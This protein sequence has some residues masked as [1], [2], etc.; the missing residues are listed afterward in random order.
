MF[1]NKHIHILSKNI[2]IYSQKE[3]QYAPSGYYQSGTGTMVT[4]AL[5]HMMYGLGTL[6]ST[7]SVFFTT[8]IYIRSILLL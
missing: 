2:H 7:F 6:E 8:K 4:N 5:K 3:R 1:R